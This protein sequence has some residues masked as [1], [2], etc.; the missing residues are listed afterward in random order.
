MY[1]SI[2]CV[3]RNFKPTYVEVNI[4]NKSVAASLNKIQAQR[5]LI[6]NKLK[7]LHIKQDRQCTYDLTLRCVRATIA[8]MQKL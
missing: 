6:K 5:K 2:S 1:I 7:F 4:S 8:A 3:A